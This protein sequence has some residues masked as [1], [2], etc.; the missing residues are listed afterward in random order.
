[1]T[2]EDWVKRA[3]ARVRRKCTTGW[4]VRNRHD[5]VQLRVEGVGAITLPYPWSEDGCDDA[6][7]RI[8]LIFKRFTT[9]G[10]S[11]QQAATIADTSSSKQ[12]VDWAELIDGFRKFRPSAGEQTWKHHYLPVLKQA[13]DLMSGHSKKPATGEE[14]MLQALERWEHGSRGRQIARRNLSAFL[15]WAVQRQHLKGCYSPPAHQP[16]PQKPKRIG[17]PL[18]DEQILRLL[19]GLPDER[20]RFAIQLAATYG[21]RPEDLRHLRWR[22]GEV[23]S[24]YRKSQ[25][26]LRGA[27]TEPRR[28]HALPVKGAPDWNLAGRLK[29]GEELPPLRSD[30]KAG[31]ALR[32]YLG[33]REVWRSLQ[34]EAEAVGEQLVPYSF[35][36]RFSKQAHKLGIPVL[37]ICRAMGHSL[38]VH[39]SNYS[40]FMP[41]STAAAFEKALNS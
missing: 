37:D 17:Y 40:R 27:K 25:G 24:L 8:E 30:G 3:R 7:A 15:T 4:S 39:Q 16:E 14:L 19:D 28:L 9:E 10:A 33:R 18:S 11:L 31:Q 1:M 6:Q 2:N 38:E 21:L 20:W 35:R 36:H 32:Q 41:D 34:G 23:W 13:A 5:K 12:K 26:G 22:D 29:I